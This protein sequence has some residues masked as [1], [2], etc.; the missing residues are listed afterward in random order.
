MP[1]EHD[2]FAF[3]QDEP[4]PPAAE[5]DDVVRPEG[6]D[7]LNLFDPVMD[8]LKTVRDPEIPIDLVNLGLI[9]ELLVKQGGTV[10]VEMTLTTPSCPVAASMPDEVKR[11]IAGVPGVEDVRVKLVW[12]PPWTQDMMS[13]E[14]RLELG[15]M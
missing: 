13:E 14:A 8:A 7:D 11:A 4:P 10:F 15:L 12:S 5:S 1:A 3:Q 2:Y 6:D 9:Y